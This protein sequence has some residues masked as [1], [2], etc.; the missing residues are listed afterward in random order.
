MHKIIHKISRAVNVVLMAPIKI[1]GKV[2]NIV[3]YVAVALGVLESV[4]EQENDP[5]EKENIERKEAADEKS[6]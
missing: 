3:K 6:E 4:L 2:L 1:P 5:D